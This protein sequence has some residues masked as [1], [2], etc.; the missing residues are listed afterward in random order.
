M[1][2]I[3]RALLFTAGCLVLLTLPMLG[4]GKYL[5][6]EYPPSTAANELQ[7]GVTYILWIPDDVTRRETSLC[8]D[9]RQQ[10]RLDFEAGHRP[11]VC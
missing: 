5:E 11:I 4:A 3:H 8:G 1:K 7:V 6:I 2:F 9:H 10:R